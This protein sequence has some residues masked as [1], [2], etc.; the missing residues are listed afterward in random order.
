MSVTF[1]T[2]AGKAITMV[3]GMRTHID[4]V[5]E[6]LAEANQKLAEVKEQA[7]V[8]RQKIKANFPPERWGRYGIP[9]K[10]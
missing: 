8:Y 9:D 10:R 4:E 6:R 5:A 2:N 7:M 3:E 1:E